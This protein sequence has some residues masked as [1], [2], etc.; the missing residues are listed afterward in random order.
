M[1][2]YSTLMGIYHVQTVLC[3]LKARGPLIVPFV[4]NLINFKES[5]F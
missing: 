4:F 3:E 5:N 2:T 1:S